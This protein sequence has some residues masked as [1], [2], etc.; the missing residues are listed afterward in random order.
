[1]KPTIDGFSVMIVPGGMYTVTTKYDL[2]H[3]GERHALGCMFATIED[4]EA[5][6]DMC[7]E[8]AIKEYER[9]M[10]QGCSFPYND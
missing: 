8:M 1:M 4:A 10:R 6:K 9:C 3:L 5:H 2:M 7:L